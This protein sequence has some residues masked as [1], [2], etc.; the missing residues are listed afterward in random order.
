MSTAKFISV[1]SFG[2]I[3]GLFLGFSLL[4]GVEILYYFTVRACCMVVRERKELQRIQLRKA[5]RPL[6][7]YDLSMVPYFI[8]APLPGKGIDEITK[9]LY[10]RNLLRHSYVSGC[11][12]TKSELSN[13]M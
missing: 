1:V 5:A 8:S 4:S 7:S 6:P 12:C 13:F 10:V 2:G 9:S 11:Y 3:A